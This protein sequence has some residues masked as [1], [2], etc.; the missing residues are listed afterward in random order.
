[1]KLELTKLQAPELAKL[2][3]AAAFFDVMCKVPGEDGRIR[4]GDSANMCQRN[5]LTA[6]PIGAPAFLI[7]WL[8]FLIDVDCTARGPAFASVLRGWIPSVR[9]RRRPRTSPN[10]WTAS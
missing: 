4:E 5:C 6:T 1:M 9:V 2:F 10:S 3:F 7:E 8:T